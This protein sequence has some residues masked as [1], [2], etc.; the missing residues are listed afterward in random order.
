MS[1]N[2]HSEDRIELIMQIDLTAEH[3]GIAVER[4]LPEAIANYRQPIPAGFIFL[5]G[6]RA[7]DLRIEPDDFKERGCNDK[8]GNPLGPATW[9]VAEIE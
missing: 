2:H 4:A 6:K 1:G 5:L 3:R 8:A 9:D 7:A